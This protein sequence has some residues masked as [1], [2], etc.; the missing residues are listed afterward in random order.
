MISGDCTIGQ[1][2]IYIYVCMYVR[3]Y[4]HVF[5]VAV[6]GPCAVFTFFCFS[7]VLVIVFVN[8]FGGVGGGGC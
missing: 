6:K 5:G 4:K 7:V 8:R 1:K 2:T 3:M